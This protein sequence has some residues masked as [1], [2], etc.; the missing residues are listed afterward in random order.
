MAMDAKAAFLRDIEAFLEERAI[1][2]TTFGFR[3]V[4]DGKFVARLRGSGSVTIETE[5]RV[6]AFMASAA[7]PRRAER[8]SAA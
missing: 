2:P 8:A 6:R 5:E 3:A 4:N 1:A 7:I